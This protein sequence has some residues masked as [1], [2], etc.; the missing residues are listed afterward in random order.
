M[1]LRHWA[2]SR[3]FASVDTGSRR[4]KLV[5]R[6]DVRSVWTSLGLFVDGDVKE[7]AHGAHGHLRWP[8]SRTFFIKPSVSI[9]LPCFGTFFMSL[10]R[11]SVTKV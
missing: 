9:L 6:A 8:G 3:A 4:A 10:S 1:T 11:S 7:V 5:Q 2:S